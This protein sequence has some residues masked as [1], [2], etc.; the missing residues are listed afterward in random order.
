M[1]IKL[2]DAPIDALS[3]EDT[4]CRAREA[5]RARKPL[6]QVSVNVATL[7]DMRKDPELR[8]DVESS[9][10]I[11]ADGMGI[12]LASRLLGLP[13][14]DRVAG[15]DLMMAVLGLC[16]RE[17]FRPYFLGGT[18]EVVQCAATAAR[19]KF[20]G[21]RLAGIHHGYFRPQQQYEVLEKIK[22][23]NPDCLFV[24]M[25]TP[26]KERFT[27]LQR[28][29]LNI[30]FAMGVGGSFDVLA[31]KVRRAPLWM[32]VNGLEWTYRV[33]QEPR[34]MWWRYART[35]V[36]F[37]YL[38]FRALTQSAQNFLLSRRLATF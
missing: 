7:V 15:I 16:A 8:H 20:P 1:R 25:P 24:G 26:S 18:Q 19:E 36:V 27:H 13:L 5:M 34:R 6:V 12:V 31:G 9:D 17:G 23:S 21:L 37:G 2:F 28:R 30:P 3:F 22:A 14:R 32:Q 4:V 11:S 35:N 38:I 33:Y 10:I 29:S